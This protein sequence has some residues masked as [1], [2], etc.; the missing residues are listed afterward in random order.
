MRLIEATD[1]GRGERA[2]RERWGGDV[3]DYVADRFTGLSATCLAGGV[4]GGNWWLEVTA[5]GWDRG[6][7]ELGATAGVNVTWVAGNKVRISRPWLH[8]F[9][10]ALGAKWPG[11]RG[12]RAVTSVASRDPRRVACPGLA[13][14][15]AAFSSDGT[16]K[17]CQLFFFFF[18]SIGVSN[19]PVTEEL[20]AGISIP[21]VNNPQATIGHPTRRWRVILRPL[22]T[23]SW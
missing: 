9:A 4:S 11:Q 16:G 13:P 22:I 12:P 6:H 7:A 20:I 2:R 21:R 1:E 10:G 5:K 18:S 3:Q 19:F 14:A 15:E 17:P 8:V 23:R